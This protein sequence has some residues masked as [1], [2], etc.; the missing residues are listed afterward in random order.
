MVGDITMWLYKGL[1]GLYRK[2]L[3]SIYRIKNFS[4]DIAGKCDV[5]ITSEEAKVYKRLR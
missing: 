4:L 3:T 1:E 2:A 5:N